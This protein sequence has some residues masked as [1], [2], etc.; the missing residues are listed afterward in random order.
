[1]AALRRAF[2]APARPIKNCQGFRFKTFKKVSVSQLEFRFRSPPLFVSSLSRF[3]RK[4]H[5]QIV[6][7]KSSRASISALSSR[8]R[9]SKKPPKT[10]QRSVVVAA[11]CI[12][13]HNEIKNALSK[14]CA[15]VRSVAKKL[16]VSTN[17][18]LEVKTSKK[19]HE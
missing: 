11:K 15:T 13:K 6:P 19:T 12:A 17:T 3:P 10:L 8:N 16:K 1:L 18:V 4:S 14:R 5:F 7:A 9:L 2:G